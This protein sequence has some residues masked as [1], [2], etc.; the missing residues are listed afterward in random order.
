MKRILFLLFL[1]V[2][3]LYSYA[4]LPTGKQT[5]EMKQMIAE[6]KKEITTLEDEIKTAEKEDPDAVASMK[7]QLNTYKTMLAAFDKSSATAAKP[8]PATPA[9][10]KTLPQTLLPIVKVHLNGP[11]VAPIAAQAKDHLF[12][13]KGKKINDSTLVTTKKT[14]V[15]Y[16]RK[17]LMLIIE[18]DEKKDTIF[19][20]IAKRIA[21][22]EEAKRELIDR[23]D[24]MK[25]GFIYYPYLENT[26]VIYD[27]LTKRYSEA[28]KNTI[29]FKDPLPNMPA[30]KKS[31]TPAR[32]AKGPNSFDPNMFAE[33]APDSIPDVLE[34]ISRLL[35][36][37][38]K[39]LKQLPS[40]ENFLA[41][42]R[43]EVG[44]C[45]TCDTGLYNRQE[46]A[47]SLWMERYNEQENRIAEKAASAGHVAGLLDL[48]MDIQERVT[49]ILLQLL[50][51]GTEKNRILFDRYGNDIHY[52]NVIAPV[53]LG[54]ERQ[55]QLL[56]VSDESNPDA[57]SLLAGKMY[58][59]YKKHYDEQVAAKNHDFV[60]DMPRHLGVERQLQLLGSEKV[61]GDIFGDLMSYNRF[62]LTMEIDFVWQ[63]DGDGKLQRRAT[64][65]METKEKIYVWLYPDSCR[66][67]IM[68][69]GTDLN[70]KKFGD[71]TL[72][73]KVNGGIK[74]VREQN[75]QLKDYPYTGAPEYSFR[76]PDCKINFCDNGPDTLFLAL[77]GGNEEVAARAQGDMQ[78]IAKAYTID[79]LG[80][81]SQALINEDAAGM[82]QGTQDAGN[83]ILNTIS[84]FMQQAPP[85]NTLDKIK[86]QYTGYMEMDNQRKLLENAYST[87]KARIMFNANNRSTVLTDTYLDTKRKMEN[88]VEIKK[89]LF[90]LRMVHEPKQ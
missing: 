14:V 6:L 68:A 52:F 42:P 17:R 88:E 31:N 9:V 13:Y 54:T 7:T 12:W 18:P 69:H 34:N 33:D 78:N 85:E 56:G 79:M 71:I 64:G 89:G 87:K 70:N 8:K 24:K 81:A 10:K 75:D 41:P 73:M 84:G 67:R 77:I 23:F 65:S 27:D 44:M 80:F 45:A 32:L 74:T 46:R 59:V 61:F 11:V 49:S 51:R 15:Q 2:S 72:P 76:L 20:A 48:S 35:D 50:H 43:S 39:E 5:D 28:M 38:E 37:A 82:M 57:A 16:S 26:L 25:N 3:V 47:I 22:G 30:P 60:L 1:Q 90:H 66:Y 86:T 63:Q 36:E 40:I 4:Q 29:S 21:K 83:Q 19:V 55:L 53:M 58:S 62:A